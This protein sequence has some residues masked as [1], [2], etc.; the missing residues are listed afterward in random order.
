MLLTPGTRLGPYTIESLIGTGGMGEVYKAHDGRLNRTVAIKRLIADD[1]SRFQSEARAIAAIN[2]PHI[3][4]IYDVGPDY[5]VLEYLQGEP[6][7][8][9][10]SRD[11]AVQLA[12]QIADALHA[13]HERGI[14]HRDLKPANVMVVRLGGTPHA[15]LLDFGV[16]QLASP[17]PSATRTVAGE[18]M[19][20]PAYMSP[21]QA[22]AKP[23]DARSD[24]FSFGAVLYELLAG[25]RA[26]TGDSAA[27]ILSA[28][29]R[30]DP[31]PL[32]APP[33]L[34][35]IVRRCL[36]KDPDRRFPTMADVRQALQHL[37]PASADPTTSIAVLPFAN[38]SRDADDEYFSDGLS[39]EIINALTQ[40]RGLKV[41]ARTSAFAFKGKNED[42]RTIANSLGVTHVLEGSVRRAGGR[43]RVTAQ[44]IDAADGAHRWSQRYDREMSDIFAVQDDIAAAIAG[45]LKLQLAPAFERRMPSLPA[46]EAYLR[47]RSYQWQFT[48]EAARRS[49]ECLEQAL[50]LDPE[51]A[52]PYV[53]LADYH[54]ALAAVG[55]SPSHEAMPRARELARRAL[56]IDPDLPEA[57][58][59]L[60]IVAG[61]YDYDWSEAERR[62]RLAV[63][64]EPLSPHLRQWY[65]TF[66][67]FATGRT[68]EA[69][70][71]LSRVIDED[72]LCQMWRLMRANVLPG[73]GLEHEALDDARKAVELDP[74]F[75][76]GWADLGLL[77]A[78]RHQHPEAM[79]CAERAMAGA[80][81]C[82]YSIGVMAAALANQGEVNE[83]QSLLVA[84]RGD[85]YG[86]PV[87]LA[88]YSL[89]RGEIEQA[90]AWS[91]KAVEQRFPAFI[92]R[93]I[94]AFEPSLRRSAA[95]PDV[96]KRMNLA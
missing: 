37:T 41:I 63:N 95:W 17:D 10:V 38:L 92:P 2:H 56:E 89:A 31:K 18:V 59:M 4:Q 9:P 88:V 34:Q 5:L 62:F 46:Y 70:R 61:H 24:V 19:G 78:R 40:V 32:E 20:T 48:P 77:Y 84:L 87:G 66:L 7:G 26:F 64:R 75:W 27:Q 69:R 79:Q 3:C 28:V 12:S 36:A 82:P 39:E 47:Y 1:V 81:W 50:T 42:I 23:L 51:F 8:S 52:L 55:G 14:L 15:K 58:A 16:A 93:V 73:A 49:R 29:L 96:L 94:R 83:A 68:D 91:A 21:E 85:A 90:V 30:D 35:Q 72:P 6:L 22:S 76:L 43:V 45:A 67:L 54:F 33:A 25:T 65:G 11:E 71:Q 86:G 80:P 13:A 53:G 60:G 57:H 44:L 74:G